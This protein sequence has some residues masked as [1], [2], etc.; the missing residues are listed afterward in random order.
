MLDIAASVAQGLLDTEGCSARAVLK[1]AGMSP[2]AAEAAF[3]DQQMVPT[4]SMMAAG[5]LH[6][7]PDSRKALQIA[8]ELCTYTGGCGVRRG[9]CCL[10]THY[11]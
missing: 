3:V 8:A 4:H 1:A 9:G 2:A 10:Y 11:V 6:W 5:D 7:A